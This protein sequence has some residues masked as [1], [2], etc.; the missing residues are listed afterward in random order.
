[1]T[2]TNNI[3]LAYFQRAQWTG[4]P[5]QADYQIAYQYGLYVANFVKT[6]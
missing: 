6:G 2:H 3:A 1:M 5:S 4:T